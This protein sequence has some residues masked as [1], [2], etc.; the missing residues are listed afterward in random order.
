MAYT[1]R[2]VP[3]LRA[4]GD[5]GEGYEAAAKPLKAAI[6]KLAKG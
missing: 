3:D 6:G 1:V 5:P 2:T 4:K